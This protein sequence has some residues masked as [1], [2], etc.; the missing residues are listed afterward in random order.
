MRLAFKIFAATTVVVLVLV[1][2]AVWSLLAV[3]HLV[4]AHREITSRSLPALQ[5]E[6]A[7]QAAAPRLVRLEARYLVLRDGAYGA[8]LKERIARTVADLARVDNLLASPA[9]KKSYREAVPALATYQ[10][11]VNEERAL[12]A[13]GEAARAL[14]LSEGP[15][16][17]RRGADRA[18]TQLTEATSARVTR[19]RLPCGTSK[20]ARG[21]PCSGRWVA[22][23]SPP[24]G[25]RASSPSA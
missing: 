23:S 6:V 12:L 13:K 11:Y 3:D 22:A 4:A 24:S 25:R 14:R 2:V 9:E 8:L 21:R 5:L 18:L 7:L 16:N 17:G 20:R 10:E 1:G 15:A 19:P